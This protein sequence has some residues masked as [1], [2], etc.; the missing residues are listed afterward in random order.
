MLCCINVCSWTL[1][2]TA[3]VHLGVAYSYQMRVVAGTPTS[4]VWTAG[5]VSESLV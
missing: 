2:E 3:G 4:C 1:G 5:E